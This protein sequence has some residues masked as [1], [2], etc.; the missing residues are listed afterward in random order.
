MWKRLLVCKDQSGSIL[1]VTLMTMTMLGL[2]SL[3]WW[4]RV[5]M[6]YDIVLTRERW[7]KDFY[8][9]ERAHFDV[10]KWCVLRD[11]EWAGRALLI[12][13]KLYRDKKV[14]CVIRSYLVERNK[15][16]YIENYTIGTF[17]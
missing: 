12:E 7:Y 15:K 14:V 1:V 11:T 13:S 16:K 3:G 4:R 9:T 2:L 10:V 5:S 6:Q 8:A 17:V